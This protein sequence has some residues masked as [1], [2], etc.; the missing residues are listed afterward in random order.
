MTNNLKEDKKILIRAYW[1]MR[2][3][4]YNPK[5]KHYHRYGGRGISVCER[6]MSSFTNFKEDMGNRPSPDHS[7]DRINNDGNYEP[8]NCR[9]ATK[10]VQNNNRHDN[11]RIVVDGVEKT[12]TEWSEHYGISRSTIYSRIN[13]LGY[14]PARALTQPIRRREPA[15]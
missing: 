8:S 14:D 10:K 9:W 1:G 13:V 6:W 5:A 11:A 15:K 7:L 2:Q 3:R 4:C 12:I